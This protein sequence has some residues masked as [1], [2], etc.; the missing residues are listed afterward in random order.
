ME[1]DELTLEAAQS[2]EFIRLL[3]TDRVHVEQRAENE[4]KAILRP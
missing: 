3:I 2:P 1:G 4:G